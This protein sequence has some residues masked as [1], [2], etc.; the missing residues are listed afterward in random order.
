[1]YLWFAE[2]VHTANLI[3]S[4]TPFIN[5]FRLTRK[6]IAILKQYSTTI[7]DEG[8]NT[9]FWASFYGKTDCFVQLVHLTMLPRSGVVM[10]KILQFDWWLW[11]NVFTIQCKT[12]HQEML[13]IYIDTYTYSYGPT[14]SALCTYTNITYTYTLVCTWDE[15]PWASTWHWLHPWKPNLYLLTVCVLVSKFCKLLD[16]LPLIPPYN[17]HVCTRVRHPHDVEVP[18]GR[19]FYCFI[20]LN[21]GRPT[22]HAWP[23][24]LTPDIGTWSIPNSLPESHWKSIWFRIHWSVSYYE[25]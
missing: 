4:K 8:R 2:P 7:A 15:D 3:K 18:E 24:A 10:A 6:T 5:G 21:F 25:C 19:C 12:I 16:P 9:I 20:F 11:Y 17:K 13:D 22:D 14:N 23:P 1:M